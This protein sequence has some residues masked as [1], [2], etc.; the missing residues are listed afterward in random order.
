MTTAIVWFRQDLR[1][2]DN[3][4]LFY[5]CQ[6]ARQVVLLYIHAPDE[7]APWA[8]GAAS[9]WWLHQSILSLQRELNSLGVT[10]IVRAGTSSG[11]LHGLAGEIGAAVVHANA[12]YEPAAQRRDKEVSRSLAGIGVDLRLHHG[13]LLFAP[14]SVLNK[15]G[16]PYRVFTPFWK[17]CQRALS[18]DSPLPRPEAI[19]GIGGLVTITLDQLGLQPSVS[20]CRGMQESWRCGEAAARDELEAFCSHALMAYGIGRDVP[21][22]RGTSRLS[23]H[24]HHGEISPRQIVWCLQRQFQKAGVAGHVDTFIRELGWRE[25]AHHILHFFPDTSESAMDGRFNHFPW[26]HDEVLLNAWQKGLTGFPIIDAGMREL[27]QTGWMHNRVRMIVASFLIKN[28]LVHWRT[29][30]RWFWDTLVDADLASNSMG[31]QWVAGSGVD[32]APY[33]RIFNP[34]LQSKKFDADGAYIRRWIPELSALSNRYL[35]SPWLAG[36]SELAAANVKLGATYP[37]PVLDLG[38]TRDRALSCYR[39]LGDYRACNP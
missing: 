20:W 26:Q 28:C 17:N 23:P 19:K 5:A 18:V 32:A 33:F 30:A 3:P 11:V 16:E 25:F 36:P 14:G 27:W 34:I 37:M 38:E 29:G 21:G 1:L 35:H 7:L 4:A 10:L 9:R 39:A 31:W 22:I 24:L 15:Q 2:A 12:L 8:P 13:N 6:S